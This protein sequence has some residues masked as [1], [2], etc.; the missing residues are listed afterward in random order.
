MSEDTNATNEFQSICSDV[1][2]YVKALE[3]RLDAWNKDSDK[4][5]RRLLEDALPEAHAFIEAHFDNAHELFAENLKLRAKVASADKQL[6]S[7]EHGKVLDLAI[8]KLVGYDGTVAGKKTFPLSPAWYKGLQ[9]IAEG[10]KA[11]PVK[12]Q[13]IK[14]LEEENRRVKEDN[15]A[16]RRTIDEQV[17]TVEK[18]AQVLRC[19]YEQNTPVE[20]GN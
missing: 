12:D 3:K 15:A 2:P 5:Y 4:L 6:A 8:A 11:N 9:A 20:R 14:D 19:K 16:L 7:Y 18:A 1:C 17:D 13:R 10:M